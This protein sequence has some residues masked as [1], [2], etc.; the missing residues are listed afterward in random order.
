MWVFGVILWGKTSSI[1]SAVHG[2]AVLR[3]SCW[4]AL[5]SVVGSNVRHR[6]G[7]FSQYSGM[8]TA[9][10][11]PAQEHSR[12]A[13]AQA[14][15]AASNICTLLSTLSIKCRPCCRQGCP[16][17]ISRSRGLC[18]GQVVEGSAGVRWMTVAR[19]SLSSKTPH[20]PVQMPTLSRIL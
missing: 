1:G 13:P 2:H 7:K 12:Q 9:H 11:A 5:C 15:T 17:G 6:E 14:C 8:R 19:T 10:Q 4:V 18:T 16:A 3:S 20:Y